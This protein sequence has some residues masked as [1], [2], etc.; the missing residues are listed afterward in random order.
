MTSVYYHNPR[1]SKSCAALQLLQERGI[2]PQIIAYL[3]Q[4]PSVEQLRQLLQ[5]LGV[6][7]RQIMRQTEADYQRLGLD[8]ADLTEQQLLHALQQYP[9]LIE[10][11]I[12]V[13]NG[14]AVIGRPPER[15]LELL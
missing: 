7:V 3:E 12:F 5:Q 1:C 9:Q 8:Q 14:K 4:I 11:P 2:Q 10:R 15:V 13:H 6:S